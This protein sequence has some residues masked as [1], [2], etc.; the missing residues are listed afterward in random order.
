M[1]QQA[2]IGLPKDFG[3]GTA[4]TNLQLGYSVRRSGWNGPTQ[5]LRLEAPDDNPKAL[6]NLPYIYITTEQGD[7]VP[8]LAS[9]TDILATDWAV[10]IVD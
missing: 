8:W 6:I 3:I 10:A 1:N 5:F 2:A 4:I 9:Q 7:R